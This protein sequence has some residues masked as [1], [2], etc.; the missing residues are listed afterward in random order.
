MKTKIYNNL[1]F[2]LLFVC[3][4]CGIFAGTGALAQTTGGEAPP[5]TTNPAQHDITGKGPLTLH[6]YSTIFGA[7]REIKASSND[8]ESVS[9]NI[10]GVF[11]RFFSIIFTLSGILMV[12]LLAVHG[13]RMI[14][15]EFGGNVA[16]FSDAK[17][18]VK[19]AAIGTAILLLS[20]V[21]LNFIAPSLL[22]PRLFRTITGLQEI[23]QGSELYTNNITIP[24]ADEKESKNITFKDGNLTIEVC[25][26]IDDNL[27]DQIDLIK[28]ALQHGT[29]S[30]QLQKS[31]QV[32]YT[33]AENRSTVQRYDSD[34]TTPI[35]TF[36]IVSNKE[37]EISVIECSPPINITLPDDVETLVVL[38][39]VSIPVKES[40]KVPNTGKTETKVV[41]KKIWR[42]KPWRY[43]DNS[44][45]LSHTIQSTLASS[46]IC[47]GKIVGED[48]RG[49]RTHR[50][51]R[52]FTVG[53]VE[54][55]KKIYA[56]KNVIN[57][58]DVSKKINISGDK[59]NISAEMSAY[60]RSG[61]NAE[62][63]D[64]TFLIAGRPRG[65][66]D[67]DYTINFWF[68][69]DVG[70]FCI[71]FRVLA[72]QGLSYDA[73]LAEFVPFGENHCF[74]ITWET[75]DPNNPG[76]VETRCAN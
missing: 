74:D 42:G 9:R 63:G 31:Y 44:I 5:T 72:S 3:S 36:D 35:K 10:Q 46:P 64:F 56:D 1:I 40:K 55:L 62:T 32:L 57:K 39:V 26:K 8:R 29:S 65:G 33:T 47:G 58:I 45:Y 73:G 15:A 27:K 60:R 12:I 30:D 59:G 2:S 23:G 18:R 17:G 11:G 25:P 70:R 41:H 13:T 67:G 49:S 16:V 53:G 75:S 69:K 51:D 48:K 20:W 71:Q 28:G 66:G 61:G 68:T 50:S 34:S 14:Y 6:L 54:D 21:I 43:Q 76:V 24:G 4:I 22:Q 52:E 38:P 7:G 19:S 37:K